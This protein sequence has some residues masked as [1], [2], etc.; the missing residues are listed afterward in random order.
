MLKKIKSTRSDTYLVSALNEPIQGG[1][2]PSI[3]QVLGR[4]LYVASVCKIKSDAAD[5]V[6]KDVLLF[7]NR[8]RIPTKRKD[9]VIDAIMKLHA[10]YQA[11]K[12]KRSR[13]TAKQ[14]A[15]EKVISLFSNTTTL[16]IK[17]IN[18]F[19]IS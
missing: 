1:K 5:M 16:D 15:N 12:D 3:G 7:W 6:T 2:L 19:L 9:H 4:F 13:T 10:R 18:L 14:Q 11:V 17:L 8:A